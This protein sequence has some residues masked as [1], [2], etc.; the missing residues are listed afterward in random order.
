MRGGSRV[1]A[2]HDVH[3]RF[4]HPE[5]GSADPARLGG[6]LS[7]ARGTP[8]EL[9][10]K[11]ILRASTCLVRDGHGPLLGELGALSLCPYAPPPPPSQASL[12][13]NPSI[14]LTLQVDVTV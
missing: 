8:E 11:K 4:V 1:S 6:A 3:G 13:L 2:V 9:L 10:Y 5:G 14:P 12:S 7:H